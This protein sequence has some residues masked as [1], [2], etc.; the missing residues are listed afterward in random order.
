MT[1]FDTVVRGATVVT[2]GGSALLDLAIRDGRYAAVLEPGAAADADTEVDAHGLVATPGG[3]DTHTH[4]S[5]PYDGV[6][7]VDGAQGASR[8]ALLGG[9]TTVVDFVPPAPPGHGLLAA[10]HD[11]VDELAPGMAVDFALHPILLD[12]SEP[13]LAAL[14]RVVA[15]GFT[16]FKMYTTYEDRRVDDGAAWQ[17]M[18]AIA[19]LGG[20]PGFHA[21]NHELLTATLAEQERLGSLGPGDYPASRPALA[22]AEAIGM[23]ALYARRI[24]TPVYVFHVSGSEALDAVVAARHA[25][26][27]VHAET[28]THYLVHDDAVFSGPDPWRFVISPPIRGA[29]DRERLWAAVRSGEVTTVGSDHCAYGTDRKT[30]HRDDH[31]HVPAGAPGIEARTPLLWSEGRRRGLTPAELVAASSER[32]ADVLGMPHKGRIAVGADADLVLWDPGA[33]FDGADL[34]PSS[35]ATFTL[36][37]GVTGTGRPRHVLLRGHRVVADGELVPGPPAGRFIARRARRG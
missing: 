34:A 10:C 28:C 37:D 36:Y 27:T 17:L 11:R 21:E 12:A 5:W 32:A 1:G 29:A 24:G 13:V 18:R 19:G 4:I 7:T 16:S 31:R 23:V 2:S 26:S 3:I 9:T 35:P 6:R 25:G 14:P 20:L 22:E 15:D 33:P 30:A 8:A